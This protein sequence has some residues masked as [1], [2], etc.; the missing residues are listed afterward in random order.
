MVLTVFIGSVFMVLFSTGSD[1][2]KWILHGSNRVLILVV[3]FHCLTIV[4]RALLY[5]KTG[6]PESKADSS[7]F[8]IWKSSAIGDLGNSLTA[9]VIFL[10]YFLKKHEGKEKEGGPSFFQ[11]AWLGCISYSAVWGG[12]LFRSLDEFNLKTVDTAMIVILILFS[13]M[14][15]Y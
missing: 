14:L 15:F 1:F 12:V 11:W 4:W 2:R 3:F 5:F 9:L 10:D 8:I 13:I 6:H 7:T